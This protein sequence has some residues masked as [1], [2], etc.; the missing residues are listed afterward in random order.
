LTF[1]PLFVIFFAL[2]GLTLSG[3]TITA[4]TWALVLVLFL[5]LGMMS[6]AIRPIE[7]A[8][9]RMMIVSSVVG[10]AVVWLSAGAI[11]QSLVE[12]QFETDQGG[13]LFGIAAPY[14]DVQA[15]SGWWV[16]G[17]GTFVIFIGAVGLWA[18]RRDVVAAAARAKKQRLAAE[19]STKEI[20]D[21]AAAYARDHEG[22]TIS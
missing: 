22:A 8:A 5:A 6:I 20:E 15:A 13:G 19:K 7:M 9:N 10:G 16:A 18:K 2:F 11:R 4:P 12:L 3:N 21:A 17:F 14:K 1:V